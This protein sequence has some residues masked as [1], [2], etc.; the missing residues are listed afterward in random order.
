VTYNPCSPVLSV[1]TKLFTLNSIWTG[2]VPG[3]DAFFDPPYT[4]TA[5]GPMGLITAIPK[6][7]E[8]PYA[9]HLSSTGLGAAVAGPTPAPVTATKTPQSAPKTSEFDGPG[10]V[11]PPA[12]T[13]EG[14]I[15]SSQTLT[16][17]GTAVTVSNTVLSLLA[18]GSS[19]KIG[20]TKTMAIGAFLAAQTGEI[21][22]LF[23]TQILSASG[24]AITVDSTVMSLTAGGS[25][26]VVGSQTDQVVVLLGVSTTNLNG[27]VA[28][29]AASGHGSNTWEI[30]R[31]TASQISSGENS[32]FT[33]GATKQ[34]GDRW[35]WILGQLMGMWIV[36][37]ALL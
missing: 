13:A 27:G 7:S 5:S 11:D 12:P 30:F 10:L 31:R 2:C 32:A 18:G 8:I 16:A 15:I 19:I 20:S 3:I 36:G 34:G 29:S 14:Y 6:I 26:L 28:S 9:D 37:I 25:S 33:A 24:S 35:S 23:G 4:L 1:P 21:G 22:Y 17:G